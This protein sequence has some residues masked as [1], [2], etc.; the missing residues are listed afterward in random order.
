MKTKEA[1]KHSLFIYFSCVTRVLV[2]PIYSKCN[3]RFRSPVND[4]VKK[5]VQVHP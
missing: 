3:A 2:S 4:E 5:V 1:L